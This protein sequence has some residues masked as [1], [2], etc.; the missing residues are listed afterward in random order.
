[1][2]TIEMFDHTADVGLRIEAESLAELFQLAA[3]G[4][5]DYVVANRAE[6]RELEEESFSLTAASSADLLAA[7]L[8]ELIFFSETQHRLYSRFEVNISADG[9]SLEA[10]IYG[11]SIDRSRHELDHEVKAVTQHGLILEQ[12]RGQW[13]AEVILDI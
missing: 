6:V 13:L 12:R 9:Q 11:E 4:M 5:F 3:V 10:T 8:S 2:G 7:W 1:M